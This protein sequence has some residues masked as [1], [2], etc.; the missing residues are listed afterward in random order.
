M[1]VYYIDNINEFSINIS[2]LSLV[3]GLFD[4]VHIGHAQLI[5]FARSNTP[6]KSLGLLTFDRTLKDNE[7]VLI[8][9]YDKE[10][11][12][13]ELGVDHLF[14]IKADDEFK[15]TSY[16]KFVD[17]LINNFHPKKIFCGPDFRYGYLAK[18]D[19][20]YL[21]MRF[22]SVY[23]LDFIKDF[24]ENKIAS[25]TI[26]KLIRDGEVKEA[27]IF[28]GR[29]YK[30]R[31][32]VIHGKENGR[33]I[34]F[35]TANILPEVEYVM[36]KRGVYFTKTEVDGVLFNS[37]TNIGIHP[38]ISPLKQIL[39]ETHI[40]DFDFDIYDE[41]ISVYFYEFERDEKTFA[42]LDELKEQINLDKSN[43]KK[44]FR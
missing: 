44:Y 11:R 19:V 7:G 25:S 30:I 26:K 34:G 6:N 14:I 9:E 8:N 3:L 29:P 18:G 23:V 42:S 12:F 38:S 1:K 22:S 40:F 24:N 43:A 16:E 27:N 33:K 10:K 37:I 13:E 32:K 39:I 20:D 15:K 17:C 4:G 35:K 21:K 36:P 5:S 31:G 2:N 28:L 41:N